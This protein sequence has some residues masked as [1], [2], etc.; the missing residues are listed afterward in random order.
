MCGPTRFDHHTLVESVFRA[1]VATKEEQDEDEGEDEDEGTDDA[2]QMRCDTSLNWSNEE[3]MNRAA[4]QKGLPDFVRYSCTRTAGN[5]EIQSLNKSK[6]AWPTF[7]W[8]MSQKSRQTVV[9]SE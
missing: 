6:S 1:G 9:R 7:K 8:T 5:D 2:T 3:K 4:G